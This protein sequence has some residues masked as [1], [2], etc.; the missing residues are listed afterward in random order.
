MRPGLPLGQAT[1]DSTQ[2]NGVGD[3]ILNDKDKALSFPNYRIE[4]QIIATRNSLPVQSNYP[5]WAWQDGQTIKDTPENYNSLLEA[6]REI[7]E[8]F[9]RKDREKLLK[10]H[11]AR[12]KEYAI[13]YYLNGVEAGHDFMNTGRILEKPDTKLLQFHTN[14][15]MLDVFSNGKMARIIDISQYH[16][17]VFR[18]TENGLLHRLKFGFYKNKAGKWIMI[19]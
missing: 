5:R 18:N 3:V 15:S 2:I 8:A 11:A 7:Y 13:A 12:S 9:E 10:L 6:Y 4:Q 17:I 19:R 16:P 14:H 1:N